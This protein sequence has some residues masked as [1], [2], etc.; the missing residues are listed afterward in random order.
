M[1]S[2]NP[3]FLT[4]RHTPE[5]V[6]NHGSKRQNLLVLHGDSNALIPSV[7]K[8]SRSILSRAISVLTCS[9]VYVL[10]SYMTSTQNRDDALSPAGE[11]QV[12]AACQLLKQGTRPPTLVK[13]SLAASSIDTSNI[14]G[15]ELKLGRDRLVPEFTFL[16][17]RAVGA[18]DM[19]ARETTLPAVFALDNDEAGTDG[20]QGRPPANEDGTPHEVLA[21]QAIRLRQVM[22][23]LESQYSGDT[24]LLIFPD[25]TGPALLS[26]MIAGIPYNRVHELEFG[27]GEVRCD[28][29]M[30]STLALWKTKQLEE[31][32]A[33]QAILKQ[34]RE[35]LKQ[36]RATAK[37]GGTVVNLKDKKIEEERREIDVQMKEKELKRIEVEKNEQ[38]L[39]FERQRE[40][41]AQRGEGVSGVSLTALVAA[42]V[43][44]I[45]GA[46]LGAGTDRQQASA[47]I[48]NVT[49]LDASGG[50]PAVEPILELNAVAGAGLYA[51]TSGNRRVAAGGGN[52]AGTTIET[53]LDPKEAAE[54]AME[55][56]MNKDDGADEWLMSLSQIIEEP[57]VNEDEDLA[58]QVLSKSQLAA[59]P[60]VEHADEALVSQVEVTLTQIIEESVFEDEDTAPQVMESDDEEC[61]Q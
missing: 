31:G 55:E 39:R 24:I 48:N 45:S 54:R 37:S 13:Y 19:S 6:H 50:P 42:T 33:F 59:E 41:E 23:V 12:V 1:W 43:A 57:E 44:V 15:R 16:D 22:S 20:L 46:S 27:P 4:V 8:M 34:G 2:T 26:A 36:L 51:P 53:I 14:V 21:E 25:G 7:V 40:V 28:V 9:C 56:Y 17:P 29:T 61:F 38:E 18:W 5:L 52:L 35:N 10:H 30:D 47:A 3:L 60:K 11:E 32:E 49:E 58:P